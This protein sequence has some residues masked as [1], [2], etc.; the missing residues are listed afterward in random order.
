MRPR[1]CYLI[2]K[3]FQFRVAIFITLL[4]VLVSASVALFIYFG[5][6]GL[7]IPEFSDESM[8]AKIKTARRVKDYEIVRY[9]LPQSEAIDIFKEAQLLSMHEKEVV[10]RILSRVNLH[11]L[12]RLFIFLIL[13]G[14]LSLVI[15]HRVAGPIYRFQNI[16]REAEK[17]NFSPAVHLRKTD[18]FKELSGN[19]NLFFRSLS[20][21]L[22]KI[23]ASVNAIQVDIFDMQSR[24]EKASFV[25]KEEVVENIQDVMA[26]LENLKQSL[27]K[28]HTGR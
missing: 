12:P 3:G 20:S 7:I 22:N 8:V 17:G 11:L 1:R 10:S 5:I 25:G 4:L 13:I 16:L 21:Q 24:L 2:K 27:S 23:K 28:F 15:S 14:L 18:E 9:G 26:L 6:V 19:F